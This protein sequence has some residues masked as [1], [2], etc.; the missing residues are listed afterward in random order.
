M[1]EDKKESLNL[2]KCNNLDQRLKM[3]KRTFQNAPRDN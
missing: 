1:D 2:A 3:T